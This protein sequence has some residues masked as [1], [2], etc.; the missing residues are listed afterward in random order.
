MYLRRQKSTGLFRSIL[1]DLKGY[2]LDF[3]NRTVNLSEASQAE[4]RGGLTFWSWMQSFSSPSRGNELRRR[5]FLSETKPLGRY[6]ERALHT[7]A[8]CKSGFDRTLPNLVNVPRMNCGLIETRMLGRPIVNEAK[9]VFLLC[10]TLIRSLQVNEQ[11]ICPVG[12]LCLGD[13]TMMVKKIVNPAEETYPTNKAELCRRLMEA[14]NHWLVDSLGKPLKWFPALPGSKVWPI[15]TR[16]INSVILRPENRETRLTK[17]F[18]FT[19]IYKSPR[20][21][22]MFSGIKICVSSSMPIRPYP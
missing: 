20:L 4:W 3:L 7:L 10:C 14:F 9:G 22:V 15:A 18:Q 19:K 13:T 5:L 2:F 17:L 11:S 1:C 8:D 21:T 12:C 16:P 6:V